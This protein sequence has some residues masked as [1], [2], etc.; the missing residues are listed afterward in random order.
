MHDDLEKDNIMIK[1]FFALLSLMVV[2]CVSHGASADSQVAYSPAQEVIDKS[3]HTLNKLLSHQDYTEFHNLLPRARAIMVF[4][5]LYKAGF[6]LGVERGH[7]VL[8]TRSVDQDGWRGPAFFTMTSGSLGLQIGAQAAEIVL[9]IMNDKGVESILNNNAKL[10]A[11]LSI[12]VGTIGSGVSAGT[13]PKFSSDI[14]A[15]SLNKGFFAGGS[16][17]GSWLAENTSWNAQ[18]YGNNLTARQILLENMGTTNNA[19]Q[20][21]INTLNQHNFSGNSN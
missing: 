17:E 14:Y 9:L 18:I 4:P 7:G 21:L 11:D 3:K 8:L 16:L 15:F 6:I 20:D 5:E 10:G 19:A 1:K 13:D 2:L 12:A